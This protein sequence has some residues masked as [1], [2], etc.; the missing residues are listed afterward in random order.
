MSLSYGAKEAS[1]NYKRH[2]CLG[3]HET[4]RGEYFTRNFHGVEYK[5]RKDREPSLS[6]SPGGPGS[7]NEVDNSH[8]NP[9]LKKDVERCGNHEF[10]TL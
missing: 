3:S 5:K 8:E 7:D 2:R 10:S 9:L 4:F 6:P 1:A